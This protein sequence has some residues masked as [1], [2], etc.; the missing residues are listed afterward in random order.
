MSDFSITDKRANRISAYYFDAKNVTRLV[1][2]IDATSM[3]WDS[4]HRQ[5]QLIGATE[6]V[7]GPDTTAETLSKLSQAK[8]L[9]RFTF[10]PLEL[11]ERQLKMEEMTNTEL[12]HRIDLKKRSGQDTNRDE[13]DY[14]AKYAMA[15]TS[16]IVVLFG[17]PFA[18]KKKRGGLSFEFAIA[19]FISFIFLAFT[20]VS[21]TFGYAGEV[22][23]VV[24]A[25]AANALFF[26]GSVLVIWRAQK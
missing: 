8:S 6:R 13:V 15:F 2:R 3:S 10:T 11:R 26:T 23:P 19:I 14:Y 20:K 22:P 18:S 16:L 21:Q 4:T 12:R 9:I 1:R 17:V 5:W 24:T 25:W 7:F